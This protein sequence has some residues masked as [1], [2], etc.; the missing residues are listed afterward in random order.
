MG[1]S[2]T[3]PTESGGARPGERIENLDTPTILVDLDRLE[4]NIAT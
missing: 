3:E 1:A 4:R 2:A